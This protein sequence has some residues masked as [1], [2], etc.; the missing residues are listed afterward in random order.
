[1]PETTTKE[2]EVTL[3][4]AIEHGLNEEEFEKIQQYLGRMPNFTELGVYS[5]MLSEHCSYKNSILE[6]K[7]LEH[8]RIAQSLS[9]SQI[10]TGFAP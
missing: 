8:Q 7:K 10:I 4:L 3:E 1:M 6:I 5:V 9:R 2:P